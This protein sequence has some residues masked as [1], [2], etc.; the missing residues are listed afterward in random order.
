MRSKLGYIGGG[1]GTPTEECRDS[2]QCGRWAFSSKCPSLALRGLNSRLYV[3]A[4][5]LACRGAWQG[6]NTVDAQRNYGEL[7]LE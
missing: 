5:Y 4:D 6:P 3:A 1:P 7:P 2:L